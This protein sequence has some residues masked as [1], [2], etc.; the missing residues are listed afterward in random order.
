MITSLIWGWS[1]AASFHEMQILLLG[2]LTQLYFH[3][4]SKALKSEKSK[5]I[6]SGGEQKFV[7]VF[8]HLDALNCDAGKNCSVQLV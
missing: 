5:T 8:Q 7:N 6:A 4:F 2:A 3:L 1:L